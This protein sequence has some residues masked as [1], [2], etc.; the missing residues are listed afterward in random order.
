[1]NFKNVILV[2]VIIVVVFGAAAFLMAHQ[3]HPKMDS[4]VIMTSADNITEG[5][6]VTLK[7]TNLNNTP[8]SNQKLNV[9]IVG[10]SGGFVQKILTTDNQGQASLQVDNSTI[11]NC[12]IM[13]KYGGNDDY[14]GCNFTDNL[15]I[16]QKV[17]IQIP[18]NS[19]NILGNNTT[20]TT[21]ASY[22]QNSHEIDYNYYYDYGDVVTVEDY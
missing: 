18:T 3:A 21:N 12:I 2:I 15:I 16:N 19:T 11:G 6:N 7:L 14:N 10:S 20:K 4:K 9:T 13:V 1:M 17:V 22:S 8:L 5:D